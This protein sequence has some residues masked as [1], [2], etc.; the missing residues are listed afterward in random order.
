MDHYGDKTLFVLEDLTGIRGA[1]EKVK[2][3]DRDVSVSWAFYDFRT[4]LEYKA[5]LAGSKAIFVNPKYTS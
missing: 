2:L 4:K 3:K 1:T 5:S